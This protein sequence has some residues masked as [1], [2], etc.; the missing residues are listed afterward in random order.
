MESFD[1]A[2]Q[3]SGVVILTCDQM[4]ASHVE[5]FKSRNQMSVTLFKRVQHLLEVMAVRFAE[6]VKMKALYSFRK[7]V[8]EVFG[9]FAKARSRHARIVD[10]GLDHAAMRIHAQAG[11][12]L[13]FRRM[14]QWVKPAEL[15]EGIESDVAAAIQKFGE[16]L[17]GIDGAVGMHVIA[18]IFEREFHLVERACC[19]ASEILSDHIECLPERVCLERHYDLQVAGFGNAFQ[20]FHIFPQSVFVNYVV[21]CRYIHDCNILMIPIC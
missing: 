3:V 13:A 14:H 8:A 12:Y 2:C 10:V 20:L 18:E 9:F 11:R 15:G 7:S 17:V 4:S 16:R 6:G 19:R 21:W 1:K 5:P